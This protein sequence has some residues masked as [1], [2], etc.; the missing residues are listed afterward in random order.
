MAIYDPADDDR[1]EDKPFDRSE[2]LDT[3]EEQDF[4]YIMNEAG[5]MEMLRTILTEGFSGYY[6]F[7]DAQLKAELKERGV[8]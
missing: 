1:L 4:Q 6:S 8:L 5:G 3:L 7:T 2:A